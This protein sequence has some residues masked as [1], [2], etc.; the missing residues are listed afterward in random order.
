VYCSHSRSYELYA[1]SVYHRKSLVAVSCPSWKD[2]EDKKCEGDIREFMGHDT[3][4]RYRSIIIEFSYLLLNN[5]LSM[6]NSSIFYRYLL[7]FDLI[8][9]IL[10]F[11]YL[12]VFFWLITD[13]VLISSARGNFFLK[14]RS[15]SPYGTNE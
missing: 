15:T 2:F 13:V 14:T 11:I 3:S 8:Y 9:I 12:S 4:P 1:D 6:I 10:F 5:L 7:S